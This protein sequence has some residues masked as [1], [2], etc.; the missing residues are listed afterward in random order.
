[1]TR[2]RTIFHRLVR[3]FNR[4]L[5][6]REM[7]T[8]FDAH[9]DLLT[10]ANVRRG[11]SAQEARR[12]ARREFG[13][14]E[15]AKE[16]YRDQVGL[17]SLAAF[18]RDMRLG[19]RALR[20]SPMFTIS[21]V[22]TLAL[23]LGVFTAIFSIAES[24]LWKPFPYPQSERL[25]TIYAK[26]A[27]KSRSLDPLTVPEYLSWKANNTTLEELA[28][29]RWTEEHVLKAGANLER[30]RVAPVTEEFLSTLRVKPLFGRDFQ[31]A[32]QPNSR[33]AVILTYSCWQRLFG[34][35]AD[36]SGKSIQLENDRHP[37]IGVLPPGFAFE[38][39]WHVDVFARA[40]FPQAMAADRATRGLQTIGRL[41]ERVSF[42]SAQTDFSRLA[43]TD[44]LAFPATDGSWGAYVENFRTNVTSYY[45][46]K[47]LFFLG[48]A[49][50][51]FVIAC[52][53]AANL[54]L[55]R[56]LRRRPELALRVSLGAGRWALLRH[57]AGE[58]AW[59]AGLASFFGLF[60]AYWGTRLFVHFASGPE[61]EIPRVAEIGVD[62]W[63]F[64]F[65]AFT[66]LVAVFIAGVP[67][68]RMA[69]RVDPNEALK[70]GGKGSSGS[71][72]ESRIRN[73]LVIGELSLCMVLLVG[74]GL[75][76]ASLVRLEHLSPGFDPHHLLTM[77]VS[78]RG[79]QL[80]PSTR[81]RT[82]LDANVF[83]EKVRALPDV[84]S[85]EIGSTLPFFSTDEVGF[86]IEGQPEPALGMEPTTSIRAVTPNYFAALRIPL[87]GGRAFVPGDGPNSP[88]VAIVNQN[89]ARH[90]FGGENP[91]GRAVKVRSVLDGSAYRPGIFEIVGV[92]GNSKEVALDEVDFDA[93]YVPFQ[94]NPVREA[95]LAVRTY[96]DAPGLA[97]ALR[98]EASLLD[99]QRPT[100]EVVPMEQIIST[101]LSE[102]RLH[103]MLAVAFAGVAFL[104]AAMGVYGALSYSVARRSHEIGIRMALGAQRSYV[105]AM[106][107][108]Q[109][110]RLVIPG[111]ALGL[112]FALVLGQLLNSM[113]YLV[114]QEHVGLIYG[115][116]T[117]DPLV[118]SAAVALLTLLA[119]AGTA[120]PA[121]RATRVDP[122]TALRHE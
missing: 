16:A 7:Q 10:E 5:F 31:G 107:V 97:A 9:L 12:A 109:S 122:M 81:L 35:T 113:L 75:F 62:F 57:A 86:G 74:A 80:D 79:P 77:R 53:N 120:F 47:L 42:A 73:A 2:W 15:Q 38:Y 1:V 28:A 118:L 18:A 103:L 45:Q 27:T 94:Q 37:V 60:L 90:F 99:P 78:L 4:R 36:L 26:S 84:E 104:L 54:L 63:V 116:S 56:A 110:C 114:P 68:A 111:L 20:T 76:V 17:R 83:L 8:E 85:A 117:H 66:A 11:M 89:L 72:K 41:R 65:A 13:G 93:L 96:R 49:L 19:A 119:T 61:M 108:G 6:D 121:R 30:V 46:P 102:N 69:F 67:A 98:R 55:A 33:S 29:F 14:L 3:V 115:V 105:V 39:L 95:F 59:L 24:I 88:R 32:T 100:Y 101:S 92:V 22:F 52:A 58:S 43:Q 91:I 40:D 71:A 64:S 48:A 112:A 44:A 70:T 50:V 51:V 34:S 21:V 82:I 25:V 106:M 87:L 23:G